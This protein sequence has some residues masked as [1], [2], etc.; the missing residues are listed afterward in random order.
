M[1]SPI[2][3]N[4]EINKIVYQPCSIDLKRY[5][6]WL[7]I[8]TG[9]HFKTSDE[10]WDWTQS[11]SEDYLKSVEQFQTSKPNPYL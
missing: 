1:S 7:F 10:F 6:D 4:S 2:L 11:N 8:K 3:H 5:Q 9:L